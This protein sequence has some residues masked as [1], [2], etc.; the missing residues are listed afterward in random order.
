[1]ISTIDQTISVRL[2]CSQS[3]DNLAEG[4]AKDVTLKAG[5]AETVELSFGGWKDFNY[6]IDISVDNTRINLRIEP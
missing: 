3:D 2:N 1:M 4:D 5:K 6:W